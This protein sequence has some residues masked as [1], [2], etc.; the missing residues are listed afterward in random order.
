[1]SNNSFFD[2]PEMDTSDFISQM[3]HP[4][5]EIEAPDLD[6]PGEEFEEADIEDPEDREMMDALDYTEEHRFTAEFLLI[7]IDKIIGFGLSVFSGGEA[8]SYR[9]RVNRIQG[10]DYEAQLLAAMIKKYQM[11]LSLEWM[12]ASAM[13]IAYAPAFD[14]AM[15]DRKARVKAEQEQA[16]QQY[17]EILRAQAQAYGPAS[18]KVEINGAPRRPGD[19]SDGQ[20][21]NG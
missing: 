6:L 2:N 3:R 13:I 1:M 10:E 4:R 20:K 19:D 21:R 16:R 5:E 12:F 11:R 8:E 18:P 14:K 15:K 7:Q 9:R 17:L